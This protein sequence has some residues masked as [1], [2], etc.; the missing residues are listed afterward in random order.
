MEWS[1]TD[2]STHGPGRQAQAWG[3]DVKDMRFR[4]EKED[5]GYSK[6]QCATMAV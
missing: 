2:S 5:I 3:F 4:F 6:Q 1:D